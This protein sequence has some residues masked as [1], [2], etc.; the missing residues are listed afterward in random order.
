MPNPVPVT[1]PTNNKACPKCGYPVSYPADGVG[2]QTV[3]LHY[4]SSND[5]IQLTCNKCGYSVELP[6]AS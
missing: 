3:G 1:F 5:K 2:G 4:L 6:V